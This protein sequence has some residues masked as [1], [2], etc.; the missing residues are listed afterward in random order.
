MA[1]EVL[2]F[3]LVITSLLLTVDESTEVRLFAC[4]AL[5]EGAAMVGVCLW[6]SVVVVTNRGESL[7]GKDAI[8]CTLK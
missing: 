7:I 3:G 5:V 4:M 2:L 6:L 1:H 8:A